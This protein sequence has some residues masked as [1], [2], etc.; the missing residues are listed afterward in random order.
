KKIIFLVRDPRDVVISL[1]FQMKKRRDKFDG[2]LE[3]FIFRKKGSIDSI[4]KFYNIWK[5]NR[6]I[7]KDFLLIRYEDM[8]KDTKKELDKTLKFIGLKVDDKLISEAVEFAKFDN[9]RKMEKK[10]KYNSSRLKPGEKNDIESYKT[11]KGKVGGYKDYLSEKQICY[12][13]EK[14]KNKLSNFFEY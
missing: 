2:S 11:R 4:I 5:K 12:I 8:H 9:M 1:Y 6:G 7:P 13:N 3:D 14:I 10:N